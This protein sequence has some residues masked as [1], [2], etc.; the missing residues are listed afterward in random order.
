MANTDDTF[1]GPKV[2]EACRPPANLHKTFAPTDLKEGQQQP[3]HLVTNF[4]R[5]SSFHPLT[6]QIHRRTSFP[7]PQSRQQQQQQPLPSV[8]IYDDQSKSTSNPQIITSFDNPPHK[9]L[10]KLPHTIPRYYT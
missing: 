4:D 10:H 7:R 1:H 5:S 8:L 9:P 6:E 3:T 2:L